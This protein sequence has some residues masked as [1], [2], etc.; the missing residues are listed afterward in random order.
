V[1][2][3]FLS[4]T[5]DAKLYIVN[6]QGRTGIVPAY[7]DLEIQEPGRGIPARAVGQFLLQ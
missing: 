5:T 1:L 6:F 3:L 2:F 4:F 7:E